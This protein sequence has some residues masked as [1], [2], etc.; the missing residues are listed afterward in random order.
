MDWFEQLTGFREAEYSKTQSLLEVEGD[1]LRSRVNG[2]AYVI[3]EFEHAALSELRERARCGPNISGRL[4][5]S[6]VQGDAR[7]LHSQPDAA[8]ALFQV[9]SQFNALEMMNPEI[10][11]EDGV[12]RYADDPTQG[13]ACAIAAGAATV[14][15]NYL[16]PVGAQ[17]GQT[18]A[19][20]LNGIGDLGSAL[21]KRLGLPVSSLWDMTNGYALCTVSGLIR[22][23][24]YLRTLDDAERDALRGLLRIVVQ[25]G[26]EVTDSGKSPGPLV[27]QA[28]CSALPVA[29]NDHPDAPWEPFASLILEAAY[30]ATMWEAVCNAQRGA[31]NIVFLTRLGGGAFGNQSAWIEAAMERALGMVR[32]YDLDVRLV[33]YRQPI[34]EPAFVKRL[35]P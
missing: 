34:S 5:F 7:A 35:F 10:S 33:S 23:R 9:A 12:T 17:T 29:Y 19:V 16:V 2:R 18:G 6:L 32:D 15:R 30:E 8:G 20:Q 26:I 14:Y 11:P 31:S 13:P 22:L 21:E 27:S 4:R 24:D 3:G 25:R 28:F 1:R